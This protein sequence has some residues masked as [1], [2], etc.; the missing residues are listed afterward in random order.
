MI[1]LEDDYRPPLVTG[2][3]NRRPNLELSGMFVTCP[4]G[5]AG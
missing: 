4:L 5:R 1:D 3:E 2:K